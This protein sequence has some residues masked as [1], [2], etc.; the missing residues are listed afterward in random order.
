MA[1]AG[2]TWFSVFFSNVLKVNNSLPLNTKREYDDS[3]RHCEQRS[4]QE[5]SWGLLALLQDDGVQGEGCCHPR[6]FQPHELLQEGKGSGSPSLT[7]SFV[8]FLTE[9]PASSRVT[10]SSGRQPTILS[11]FSKGSVWWQGWDL[12]L[13][14]CVPQ[15][16]SPSSSSLCHLGLTG[17]IPKLVVPNN[18]GVGDLPGA[19]MWSPAPAGARRAPHSPPNPHGVG[20]PD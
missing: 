16:P 8:I 20:A 11:M 10:R 19:S 15:E 9:S 14:Y 18:T 2:A 6:W 1:T 4:P 3:W 13:L 17:S 7:Q 5:R 12:H